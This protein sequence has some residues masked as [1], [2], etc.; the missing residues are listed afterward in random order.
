MEIDVI[1]TKADRSLKLTRRHTLKG[2]KIQFE[3]IRKTEQ[4]VFIEFYFV[5]YS[6][7]FF[8][9]SFIWSSCIYPIVFFSVTIFALSEFF[10]SFQCFLLKY[11][12]VM[13][14]VVEH[15]CNKDP[16]NFHTE[17]NISEG[18]CYRPKILC[19]WNLIQIEPE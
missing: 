7:G 3:C 19:T 9:D 4:H 2:P 11:R 8:E 10:S 14:N 13:I 16:P 5:I 12:M 17:H 15:I 18:I 1:N 6:L